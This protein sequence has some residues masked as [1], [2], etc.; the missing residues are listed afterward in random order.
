[1]LPDWAGE[2]WNKRRQGINNMT[3]YEFWKEN[4]G[5]LVGRDWRWVKTVVLPLGIA[6]YGERREK[7]KVT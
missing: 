1:M 4:S 2:V 6:L 5:C 7:R 3:R